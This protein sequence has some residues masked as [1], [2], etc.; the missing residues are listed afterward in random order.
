MKNGMCGCVYFVANNWI[1]QTAC[2]HVFS[3]YVQALAL[4]LTHKERLKPLI[5]KILIY[6][7]LNESRLQLFRYIY[8]VLRRQYL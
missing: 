7:A 1:S 8:I 3:K 5:E 4:L 2:V 6:V